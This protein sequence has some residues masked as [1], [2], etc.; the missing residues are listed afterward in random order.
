MKEYS[1]QA[2]GQIMAVL[3]DLQYRYSFQDELGVFRVDFRLR[4]I[5]DITEFIAVEA[6]MYSVYAVC[7]IK[8][9]AER[10]AAVGEYIG[11][12][13]RRLNLCSF[14]LDYDTGELRAHTEIPFRGLLPWID[15]VEQS[16]RMPV[17]LFDRFGGGLLAV[18]FGN[19]SP[20]ETAQAALPL[21][22][23]NK[24]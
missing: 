21:D 14:V 16:I 19:A 4:D 17:E 18:V 11:R 24:V 10:V 5:R 3:H 8:I 12:I 23:G 22:T 1:K 13:N 20:K 7:P 15:V 2:V 9:P 6:Q